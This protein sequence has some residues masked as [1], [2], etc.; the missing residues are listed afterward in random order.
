M[1]GWFSMSKLSTILY[2]YI[3][4]YTY[5]FIL[6]GFVLETLESQQAEGAFGEFCITQKRCA[7]I[8][9]G[10]LMSLHGCFS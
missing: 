10:A 9:L 8:A 6:A 4:I 1:N 2:T 3:Y 5:V 7:G